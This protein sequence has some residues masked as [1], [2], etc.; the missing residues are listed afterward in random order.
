MLS[1]N[2]AAGSSSAT[3]RLGDTAVAAITF[4][5]PIARAAAASRNA[6]SAPPLNATTMFR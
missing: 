3:G 5:G 1:A 4:A 6:E 2:R